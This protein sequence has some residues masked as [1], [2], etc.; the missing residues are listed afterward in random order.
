[1]VSVLVVTIQKEG[2]VL[3]AA[4]LDRFVGYS[5][6]LSALIRTIPLR[7]LFASYDDAA[8]IFSL[9]TQMFRSHYS[10]KDYKVM[11]CQAQVSWTLIGSLMSLGHN[12]VKVHISQLLLSWK[13]GISN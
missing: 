6:H 13:D 12:F 1:M 11:T 10:A 9:S 4:S 2:T 3:S 7:S 5:F 8:Q